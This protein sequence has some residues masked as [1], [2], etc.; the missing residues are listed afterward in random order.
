MLPYK[1]CLMFPYSNAGMSALVNWYLETLISRFCS[2]LWDWITFINR[3]PI[4][5]QFI[6][7]RNGST[8]GVVCVKL[9]WLRNHIAKFLVCPVHAHKLK[10]KLWF[11]VEWQVWRG[12]LTAWRDYRRKQKK[13][14]N[15]LR[16]QESSSSFPITFY[17]HLESSRV[18][19]PF[20]PTQLH[21]SMKK[22]NKEEPW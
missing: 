9:I 2:A 18:G 21:W 22:N 19:H 17:I 11:L 4:R 3:L 14:K 15:N 6:E 12:Y 13:T 16:T 5:I 1:G 7:C 20:V 8:I 10:S